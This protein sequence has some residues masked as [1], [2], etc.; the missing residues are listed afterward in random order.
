M[1]ASPR[2]LVLCNGASGPEDMGEY[3]NA[4]SLVY[5]SNVPGKRNI[6]L[7]LPDFVRDVYYLP[8]RVL[9][10]LEIAAYVFSADRLI[11]RGERDAIEYHTWA[12]T[13]EFRIRVR[14]HSFWSQDGVKHKLAEALTFIT[15]DRDFTFIFQ[16]SIGASYTGNQSLRPG[17]VPHRI[18]AK[19]SDSPFFWRSG[20]TGRRHRATGD[21]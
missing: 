9:D 12:R 16:F 5:N 14:D 3:K 15:G 17:G 7:S 10:L 19:G 20:F 11:G 8:E 21:Q 18:S 13:F 2:V 6:K 1:T 4:L